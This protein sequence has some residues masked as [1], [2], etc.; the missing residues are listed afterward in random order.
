MKVNS[1]TCLWFQKMMIWVCVAVLLTSGGCEPLR[2]K[3]M[4]KKKAESPSTQMIP[5]LEPIDYADKVISPAQHYRQYYSRWKVWERD[6]VENFDQI[7]NEKRYRYLL[8]QMIAQLQEMNKVVVP[9]K[10]NELGA[11]I[12]EL[13][14]ILGEFDK[15]IGVRNM[16]SL[17][18]KLEVNTKKTREQFKPKSMEPFLI[19]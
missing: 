8:G 6:L 1:R 9:E 4:R 11:V 15:P 3:F 17:R 13:S 18:R 14:F 2:K 5:V 19:K 10:Q 7:D 16:P 12:E